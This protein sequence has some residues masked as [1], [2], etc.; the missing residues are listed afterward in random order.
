MTMNY[1]DTLPIEILDI[2]MTKKVKAERKNF[3]KV[4][5][6]IKNNVK[7]YCWDYDDRREV[8]APESEK[9]IHQSNPIKPTPGNSGQP[10]ATPG[11][12]GEPSN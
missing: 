12:P 9:E 1:L 5:N 7:R 10:R 8:L 2:I 3:D 11:N 6:E 4:L